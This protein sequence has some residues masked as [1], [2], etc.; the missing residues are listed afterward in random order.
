MKRFY[1]VV[2]ILLVVGIVGSLCLSPERNN[3]ATKQ[4][5]RSVTSDKLRYISF[6]KVEPKK[7]EKQEEVKEEEPITESVAKAEEK[8]QKN[9]VTASVVTDVL[10]TQKGTMSAYG[11]DCAGC[12]GHLSTGFDARQSITYQDGKYGT[13]RIVAG[14]RK[15]P[16]GTIVRIKGAGDP[17]NAIV[18]DR[19][20]DIGIG[21]RFMFDLLCS[22]EAQASNYGTHYNMTFEILRYGY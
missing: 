20:G 21:R 6:K 15:Y 8:L 1:I 12:N 9:I 2:N 17:F 3:I 18:L 10:E 13:V 19:G 7:E 5:T 22:S 16:F 4:L 14:D 11:P